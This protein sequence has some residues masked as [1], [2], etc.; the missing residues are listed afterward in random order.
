VNGEN[1]LVE[2][3]IV[4]IDLLRNLCRFMTSQKSDVGFKTHYSIMAGYLR[5]G[6]TV[7]FVVEKED[8]AA[9]PH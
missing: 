2:E 8:A 6:V 7:Y 9:C 4:D 1:V 5:S 3:D